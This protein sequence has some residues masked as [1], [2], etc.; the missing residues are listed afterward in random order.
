MKRA[1]STET[2]LTCVY[3]VVSE[4]AMGSGSDSSKHFWARNGIFLVDELTVS[5][6]FR[7]SLFFDSEEEK[8]T[9]VIANICF[10]EVDKQNT[11]D[12]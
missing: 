9:F 7:I 2:K 12:I 10:A 4:I 3:I 1:N 5:A 6:Y 8:V 11:M